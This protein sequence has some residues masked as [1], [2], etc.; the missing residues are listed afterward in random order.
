M[1]LFN[2]LHFRIVFTIFEFKLDLSAKLIS[3]KEIKEGQIVRFHTPLADE[4]PE[5]IYVVLE[6]KSPR[7]DI[8]A[9]NTG[10]AIVPIN[11]VLLDDLE[12]VEV[13][14]SDLIG[15]IVT[16]KKSDSTY[17]LGKV[18]NADE[19]KINLDLSKKNNG[20]ETNVLIKVIDSDGIE[21]LGTLFIN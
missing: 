3:M 17:V 11:T 8:Q 19:S 12:V 2:I 21:H 20:I 18:V 5:Q 14:T 13:C 10:L 1:K 6:I 16:I 15:H 9:L 4:N 7:V